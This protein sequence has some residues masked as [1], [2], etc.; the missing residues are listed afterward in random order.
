[1][2]DIFWLLIGLYTACRWAAM[3]YEDWKG[4]A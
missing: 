4:G 3:I 1:M 2:I